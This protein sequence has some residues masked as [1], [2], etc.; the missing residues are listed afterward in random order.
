MLN[1]LP[2]SLFCFNHLKTHPQALAGSPFRWTSGPAI[3][4]AAW[5][6]IPN[7]LQLTAGW[8]VESRLCFSRAGNQIDWKI[9]Q[10]FMEVTWIVI[11]IFKKNTN[12]EGL[13]ADQSQ[14]PP[15]LRLYM[16]AFV[17]KLLWGQPLLVG[18]R[19]SNNDNNGQHR[20][21]S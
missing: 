10:I 17:V 20:Q 5:M 2:K 21:E 3:A 18:M 1:E 6:A 7:P 11:Y 15:S 9:C 13:S 8:L 4:P 12:V 16:Y 14:W 19:E